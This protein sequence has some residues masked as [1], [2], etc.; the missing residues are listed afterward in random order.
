MSNKNR[1]VVDNATPI[2]VVN[3]QA[4]PRLTEPG[5]VAAQT[6]TSLS[7]MIAS[8]IAA[9]NAQLMAGIAAMIGGGNAGQIPVSASLVAMGVPS[10]GKTS[11]K[12]AKAPK[13]CGASSPDGPCQRCNGPFD[14]RKHYSIGTVVASTK[15]DSD[16]K[17]A[18]V[19]ISTDSHFA[20]NPVVIVGVQRQAIVI[21]TAKARTIH[22]LLTAYLKQAN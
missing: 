16:G 10:A 13:V 6:G 17:S 1:Q 21:N 9:N 20:E 7:D 14:A 3:G 2:A 11:G 5:S 22:A 12:P 18:F 15:P 4:L 19:G 8:Q